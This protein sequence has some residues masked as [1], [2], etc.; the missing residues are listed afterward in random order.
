MNAGRFPESRRCRVRRTLGALGDLPKRPAL[1]GL[2]IGVNAVG[3]IWGFFWY[4]DQLA[5]TPRWQWWVVPDSPTASSLFTLTLVLLWLR[6]RAPWL[7]AF[8]YLTMIKYGLWTVIVL[9]GYGLRTG[10]WDGEAVLLILSHAGM[11]VE[12][13]LYQRHFPPGRRWVPVAWLWAAANDLADY[14][15]GL[16]P[17][18]PGPE[19]QDLAVGSAVLLTLFAGLVVYRGA[20]RG[21][22][23]GPER[24]DV[25]RVPGGPS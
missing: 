14:G 3:S 11:A 17:T 19:V 15:G 22:H 4:R 21:G 23:G 18:L 10:R 12:A 9:G 7:E 13:A 20:W 2:L 24:G 6:R 25:R 16:H 8:A 5:A 1:T